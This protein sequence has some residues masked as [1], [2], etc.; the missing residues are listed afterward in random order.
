M[1]AQLDQSRAALAAAQARLRQDEAG[2]N[3][4]GEVTAEGAVGSA[5]G[6][7]SPA[8]VNLSDTAQLGQ[9]VVQAARI[10]LQTALAAAQGRIS[11]DEATA[12]ADPARTQI[13]S[14]LRRRHRGDC[15]RSL[16]VS[17]LT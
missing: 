8:Q 13:T 5:R 2:R 4:T 16:R 9:E 1:L 6:A 3:N 15:R 14:G 12:A 10:A 17:V 11:A 7:L